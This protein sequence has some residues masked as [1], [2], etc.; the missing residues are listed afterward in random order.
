MQTHL[1]NQCLIPITHSL[2][3][4]QPEILVTK[5]YHKPGT[6]LA[7]SA[8]YTFLEDLNSFFRSN[9]ALVMTQYMYS[10]G[11]TRNRIR[12]MAAQCFTIPSQFYNYHKPILEK[13]NFHRI[14]NS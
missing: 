6:T 2:F 14:R 5:I 7:S 3:V 9:L 10:G 1:D 13:Q 4:T 12:L 8:V 11:Q